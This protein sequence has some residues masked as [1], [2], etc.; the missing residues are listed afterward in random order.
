MIV[1]QIS[2]KLNIS[3]WIILDL[4]KAKKVDKLSYPEL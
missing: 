1:G 4:F 2:E 3:D